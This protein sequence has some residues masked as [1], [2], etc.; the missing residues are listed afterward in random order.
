MFCF[1]ESNQYLWLTVQVFWQSITR[2]QWK[3]KGSFNTNA[4]LHHV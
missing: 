2:W 4:S 1:Q 3:G